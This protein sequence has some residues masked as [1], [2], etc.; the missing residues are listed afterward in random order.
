MI[1]SAKN[2]KFFTFRAYF[3]SHDFEASVSIEIQ[4]LKWNSLKKRIRFWSKRFPAQ[5]KIEKK[6]FK[7][8]DFELRILRSGRFRIKNFSNKHTLEKKYFPETQ[9]LSSIFIE[10]S[11]FDENV[12]SEK[13]VLTQYAPQKTTNSSLF[14]L[15]LKGMI[16]KQAFPLKIRVWNE[17][18]WKKESDYEVNFFL[19]KW[20]FEMKVFQHVRFWIENLSSRKISKTKLFE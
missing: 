20:D 14:V 10:K 9:F 7:K 11:D 13:N 8:S 12:T 17:I 15:I 1:S 4:S 16:L 5:W 18:L 2:N 3:K 6:N 19:R